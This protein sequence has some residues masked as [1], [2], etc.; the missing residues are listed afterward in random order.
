M[1]VDVVLEEVERVFGSSEDGR[2]AA[3][4]IEAYRR[5][6]PQGVRKALKEWISRFGVDVEVK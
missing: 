6:G 3:A 5:G 4:L 2:L 1:A